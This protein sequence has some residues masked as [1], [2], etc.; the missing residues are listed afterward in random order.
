MNGC[1]I[2]IGS[3]FTKVR[4]I[5]LDEG[6]LLASAQAHTTVE[7]N[8]MEGLE[9]ALDRISDE[10]G[11]TPADFD[12]RFASSSAAGG[13]RLAVVGFSPKY[14]LEAG[15]RAALGA[16]ANVVDSFTW[17]LDE[18]DLDQLQE[19]DPDLLLLTGGV[20]GGNDR[21]LRKN[22]ET[23]SQ[24]DLGCPVVLAG[25]AAVGPECAELLTESGYSVTVAE[26]ILGETASDLTPSDAREKIRRVFFEQITQAKGIDE[27]RSFI[28][29]DEVLPTPEAVSLGCQLVADGA[30]DTPGR[31]EVLA[32][33]V[34][35]AT[36]DV[37][38]IGDG[39]PTH[40]YVDL[41]DELEEPY[42]KRTVE[43]D[44]GIRWNALTILDRFG[45]DAIL[46]HVADERVTEADV[47][48]YGQAVREDLEH[49]PQT[50]REVHLD[51]ALASVATRAAVTQHAG[52]LRRTETVD[53]QSFAGAGEAGEVGATQT[54]ASTNEKQDRL[55]TRYVQ[56]GK[57]LTAF[58][59]VIGTGGI[60]ANNP[61]AKYV[62][63]TI[64]SLADD[65]RVLLPADPA[66]FIDD[67]YLLFAG[68]LMAR[69]LPEIA[70]RTIR[71]HLAIRS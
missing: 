7:T 12:R 67:E 23:L 15:N 32:V 51:K 30:G 42:R 64:G 55:P 58:D 36:T 48:S 27:I 70:A 68:G 33:D 62:I 14:T 38:S 59:T 28:T 46:E 52:E 29:E 39:E 4:A 69:S 65:D 8:V 43:A 17:Y 13:L 71:N 10:T 1:F 54:A 6:E 2:D 5:D 35:G 34:G 22:A 41:A 61:H 53:Q 9:S 66:Y 11:L 26:N 60:L 18:E 45:E 44:L 49:I 24:V 3:T 50:D 56:V 57:D 47:R 25:N 31:G 63:E 40:A 37:H 20:D 21:A 19:V 16:G